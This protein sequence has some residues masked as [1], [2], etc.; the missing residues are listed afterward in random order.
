[1]FDVFL[2]DLISNKTLFSKPAVEKTKDT[3]E[4]SDVKK[5]TSKDLHK[6]D[7]GIKKDAATKK[8][9][10]A[11]NNQNKSADAIIEEDR[12]DVVTEPSKEKRWV[13]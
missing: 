12:V 8:T 5:D 10:K 3:N 1:M 13:E 7:D 6:V 4:A 11:I 2:N 9:G